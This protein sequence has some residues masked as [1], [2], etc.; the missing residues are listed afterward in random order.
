MEENFLAAKGIQKHKARLRKET[1]VLMQPSRTSTE[2][3]T[4]EA[5]KHGRQVDYAKG[6]EM[7]SWVECGTYEIR[8]FNKDLH[9]N[10]MQG[11]W[12]LTWK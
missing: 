7:K 5:R 2:I 9:R 12:V 10:V 11:R 4:E 1:N 8:R 6:E 3:G